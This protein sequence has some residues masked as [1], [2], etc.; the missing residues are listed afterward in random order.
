M[1]TSKA[2]P[3]WSPRSLQAASATTS[4]KSSMPIA[5]TASVSTSS[6]ACSNG[7]VDWFVLHE[8]RYEPLAPASDGLLRS[9]VFPGLWLDP[10]ALI[11]GELAMVLAVVEQ[12]VNSPE[13]AEFA[14]RLRGT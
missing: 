10:A 14:A 6:G 11:R 8:G 7:E 13:H 5:A 12:G 4:A 3:N 9:R 1:I 2:P